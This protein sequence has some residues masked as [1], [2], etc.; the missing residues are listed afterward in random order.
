MTAVEE[1]ESGEDSAEDEVTPIDQDKQ[2]TSPP[3]RAPDGDALTRQT[4]E[5]S[6]LDTYDA[7]VVKVNNLKL[8]LVQSKLDDPTFVKIAATMNTLGVDPVKP[9]A[10]GDSDA[11]VRAIE[12]GCDRRHIEDFIEHINAKLFNDKMHARNLEFERQR[13]LH[14]NLEW[15]YGWTKRNPICVGET[16]WSSHSTASEQAMFKDLGKD[17]NAYREYQK[18]YES[19]GDMDAFGRLSKVVHDSGMSSLNTYTC[20]ECGFCTLATNRLCPFCKRHLKELVNTGVPGGTQRMSGSRIIQRLAKTL[21][22]D[23]DCPG[24][25]FLHRGMHSLMWR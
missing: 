4:L 8:R 14:E 5:R 10:D 19:W 16:D 6:N 1:I 20:D 9:V 2:M 18:L 23:N 24:F 15:T 17:P 13:K 25:A 11:M 22:T 7:T 21:I 3:P 12:K